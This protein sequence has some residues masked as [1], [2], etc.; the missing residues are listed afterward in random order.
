MPPLHCSRARYDEASRNAALDILARL[1]A[2]VLAVEPMM[3]A[4]DE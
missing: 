3:E 4:S 2:R 1:I